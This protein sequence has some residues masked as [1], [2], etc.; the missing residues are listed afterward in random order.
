M[1]RISILLLVLAFSGYTFAQEDQDIYEIENRDKEITTL[2][3]GQH[4]SHGGY[5]SI[6]V[7]YSEINSKQALLIGGR[8]S[9]IIGHWFGLGIGGNGFFNDYTTITTNNEQREAN[10]T[11]GYGGMVFEPIIFPKFPVHIS[12]PVLVGAGGIAYATNSLYDYYNEED[13]FIEDTYAFFIV[14][15]GVELELNMLRYFRLAFGGY[16]RYTNNIELYNTPE[17]VLHGFSGG[18]T[19][20]FG[21]F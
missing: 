2:F 11:G 14:E 3:G 5:G 8:G 20:K 12:L 10:L 17:D 21:K 9:W 19:L 1:T 16:Y 18:V 15:P 13:F 7:N 4:L 6:S